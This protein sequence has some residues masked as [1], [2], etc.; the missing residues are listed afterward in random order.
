M[1]YLD[2]LTIEII[3]DA[4]NS[5]VRLSQG[6]LD[7]ADRI[8]ATDFN[9]FSKLAGDVRAVDAGPGLGIDHLWFNLNTVTSDLQPSEAMSS[10]SGS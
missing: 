1:P 9:E 7:F 8:R 4:N 2:N 6:S 10:G 3:K 5:F